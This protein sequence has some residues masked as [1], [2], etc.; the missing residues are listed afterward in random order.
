VR[1]VE[2]ASL[3][4]DGLF[5]CRGFGKGFLAFD[6]L[7]GGSA[8]EGLDFAGGELTEGAGWD[9]KDQCSVAD[10]TN[11]F[12]VVADLFEHLAKLAVAAFGEGDLEPRVLATTDL[13]DLCGLREDAVATA[14]AD[15][16]EAAAVDHDAAAELVD[17]LVGGCAG[18][19]DEVG[20]FYSS[21]GLGEAVGEFAVVGHEEQTFG[22]VVEASHGI[23]TW[24]LHVFADGLLLGVLAEEL[25]DGGA[26]LGVV[27]GGDVAARLVDHEVA[28]RLGAVEEFAVDADVVAGGVGTGAELGDDLAVYDDA[29]FEDDGFG[30]AAAGDASLGEDLLETVALG[31]F[32]VGGGGHEGCFLTAEVLVAVLGALLAHL[33]CSWPCFL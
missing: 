11:L 12:N 32:G 4:R 6:L 8:A 15:L 16:V 21:G 7:A 17:G 33:Q 13:L 26:M 30:G 31:G 23:K 20:F 25:H 19:F 5:Q 18:D 9:V 3:W 10:A 24:E 22:E 1:F 28:L 2:A 27:G 14:A 29:A